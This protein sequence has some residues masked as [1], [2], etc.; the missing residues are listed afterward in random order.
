MFTGIIESVGIIKEVTENGSNR[1]FWVESPISAELKVDQ[2][3]AHN[4]VCLTVEEVNGGLHK[5]TAVEETLKKTTIGSWQP[6]TFINMERCLRL[7]DRIDGHLVQGHVD[8]RATCIKKKE[9]NGS[10]EFEFEFPEKFSALII[11]KGSVCLNG[12]SL[13]G[14]DVK[15]KKFKVAVVPYTFTNTTI[16]QLEKGD[17]VNIEFDLIGKYLLRNIDK[18]AQRN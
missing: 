10:W 1:S 11:E 17:E 4:G 2:S 13:T 14:F 5:V 16:N 3:V 9:K 15:R 7:D 8:T 6:G 18:I 12:I